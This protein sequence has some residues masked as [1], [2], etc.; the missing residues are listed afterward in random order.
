MCL[1]AKAVAWILTLQISVIKYYINVVDIYDKLSWSK[2]GWMWKW[3][4]KSI[5]SVHGG[6]FVICHFFILLVQIEIF[7]EYLNI[8]TLIQKR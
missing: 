6:I 8:L 4:L 3:F 7:F 2:D 1:V 5:I